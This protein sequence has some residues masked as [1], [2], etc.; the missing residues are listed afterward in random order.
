MWRIYH[1][2]ETLKGDAKKVRADDSG[3]VAVIDPKDF[4]EFQRPQVEE[5][6]AS[7][8]STRQRGLPRV[9]FGRAN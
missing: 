6:H 7:E 5:S 8:S 2:L 4:K 1:E 3:R 9:R